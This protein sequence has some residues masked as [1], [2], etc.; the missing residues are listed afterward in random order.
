MSDIVFTD[1]PGHIVT[2]LLVSV[3]M[4]LLACSFRTSTLRR[5]PILRWVLG[6]LSFVT[7]IMLIVLTWNPSRVRL[8]ENREQ[9]TLLVCLDT[10]ESMSVVDPAQSRLDQALAVFDRHFVNGRTDKP[11]CRWYGFDN[12]LRALSRMDMDRQWGSRSNLET[13]LAGLADIVQADRQVDGDSELSPCGMV[14]FTDGQVDNKQV[15]SYA[16]LPAKDCPVVIVA[17]GNDGPSGDVGIRSVKAPMSVR[18]DQRYDVEAQ[19]TGRQLGGQPVEVELWVNDV[20]ADHKAIGVFPEDGAQDVS[21]SAYALAP[22][23]DEIKVVARAMDGELNVSNNARTRLVEVRAD[24]GIRVLLY[25][26]VAS[27]DVSRIKQCLARDLKVQL[28]FVYDVLIDA[29]LPKEQIDRPGRFLESAGQLNQYDLVVLGPCRFDQFSRAQIAGLYDF[30]TKGGGSLVFLAGREPFG[31][32]GCGIEEIRTLVPVDFDN[33]GSA[34]FGQGLSLTEEGRDQHYSE[35]VCNER[36]GDDVD[37]AHASVTKKP[38]ASTVLRCGQQPLVCTQR[39]GRGKTAMVNCRNLY[40]L[41]REDQAD[42]PLFTLLADIVTDVA[43]RPSRQSHIEVFVRRSKDAADLIFEACVTDQ[44]YGPARQ[45]TVLLE[46]N[47]RITRLS[48]AWP[49]TYMA[50][51]PDFEGASVFARVRVE[52]RDVYLGE[53]AIAVELDDVKREMDD[54][55]CDKVFLQTLCEQ[56]GAEFVD[57][58]QVGSET[59]DR[60]QPYHVAQQDP[61]LQRI[62]PRWSVFVLLCSIL[63]LQ[64]FLRRAKG[65]I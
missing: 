44:T 5:L 54:T 8:T 59:F 3:V 33:S 13:A 45:A 38:A 24:A 22:G 28:D 26:Q 47:G 39:L 16:K 34:A 17:C 49:G 6:A 29:N 63:L 61:Q 18:A 11:R 50:T 2:L 53:K 31:L 4:I 57:A 40:Q 41:Y 30:V 9:N 23:I 25:S 43:E 19:V 55:R 36:R 48:E 27:F 7:V 58:N 20:L 10:S 35:S 60:F 14:V 65:L 1:Y 37:V 56:I 64:W 62:W 42:G 51:I 21:F 46:F 32:A 15:Q 12:E 52:H